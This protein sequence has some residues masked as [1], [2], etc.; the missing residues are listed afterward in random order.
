MDKAL[1]L[2]RR[3]NRRRQALQ[4]TFTHSHYGHYMPPVRVP[5][6]RARRRTTAR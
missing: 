5:Q 3:D 2:Q 6:R 1:L 4:L